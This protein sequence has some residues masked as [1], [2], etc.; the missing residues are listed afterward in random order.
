MKRKGFTLIEL[1]VVI[2][3]IAVLVGLLLPAVQ[4][5]REAAA[6]MSCSNNLKQIGLASMNYESTY[7]IL[8]P[9]SGT[10][11]AGAG[12]APSTVTLILP[13]IEGG[14]LYNLFNFAA[15]VNNSAANAAARDQQIKSYLCPSEASQNFEIDPGGSGLP[16]GRCNYA[17]CVGI[18]ADANSANG[19][20]IGIFNY[21]Y[22]PAVTGQPTL[23]RSKVL[24]TGITDGTSN[25]AMWSERTLSTA[26]NSDG[27]A[28]NNY[29]H[30]MIY[31][32]PG[33]VPP[34]GTG[35][36]AG[37]TYTSIQVGPQFNET[38]P[39]AWIVGN[40]WRCN[41]WDYGPTS[42]IRYRGLEYYRAL[43]E[44]NQYTHT[45]P[46]NYI[47][48]DCG[49]DS[50]FTTAHIAARSYH[51]GGVNVCF[52]DGSVHFISNNITFSTWQALGTRSA[53]D[54]P[55]ATQY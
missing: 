29:D 5:V 17:G 51:T 30:T 37:Y 3:I 49:D 39:A 8:P 16:V 23:V 10:L 20:L 52:A 31:L 21:Q 9:G 48:Y 24:I 7:G 54:I 46:P 14:N 34:A 50:S 44:M 32:L 19:Q 13:Y 41:S 2:A 26:S 4:K 36:D 22:N 11:A 43:P 25:T 55:D 35:A 15:D 42:I 6:R 45:L 38:N 53:G 28:D 12:S 33:G 1:L 40:T 27:G 18:T 47:G